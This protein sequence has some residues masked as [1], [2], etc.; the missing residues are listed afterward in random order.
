MYRIQKE[1]VSFLQVV[2]GNGDSSGENFERRRG[3][4]G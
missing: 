3:V 4:S 1:I 2:E